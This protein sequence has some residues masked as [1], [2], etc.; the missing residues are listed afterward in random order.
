[1]K[2]ALTVL[3]RPALD[4]VGLERLLGLLGQRWRRDPRATQAEEIVELSGCLCYM[5][6]GPQQS[7]RSTAQYVGNLRNQGHESVFEHVSWTFVLTG[8]TRAFTHQLIRHRPGFAFS[9]LSQ[10]YHDE[11]EAD[12][13]LPPEV[14]ENP[15]LVDL[16]TT[17]RRAAAEA[18]TATRGHLKAVSNPALSAKEAGRLANTVARG[19]LP[20]ATA[21][22]IAV[23][24]NARSIRHFLAVRGSLQGD[25]EMRAVASLLYLAVV[26]DAP[27]LFADFGLEQAADG[28]SMVIRTP[29]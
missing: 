28:G 10:Q 15:E 19:V 13:V 5:S 2:P 20:E 4:E 6:F 7:P 29:T 24:A 27:S 8:V 3:A 11:T 18:Y 14:S 9:Q 1:M 17:A 25:P 16:W 22:S 26:A 21:T 23:T 12:L